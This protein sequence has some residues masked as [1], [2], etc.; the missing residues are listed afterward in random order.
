MTPRPC[1]D[2]AQAIRD[3]LW[4]GLRPSW[5]YEREP[6]YGCG[7]LRHAAMN[8]SLAWRWATGQETAEDRAFAGEK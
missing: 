5:M 1:S 3:A 2:R 8:L 7:Y 4:F 6:H